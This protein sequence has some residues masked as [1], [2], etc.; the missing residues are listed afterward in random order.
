MI[1]PILSFTADEIWQN[2]PGERAESVFLS[3][4]ADGQDQYPELQ[5]LP[6]TFW[7]IILA[8]KT[9]VN[10]ELEVKRAD[11]T[12]G[13]SLS[14]EV[15]LYCD[16]ELTDQLSQLG[17][18]LQFALIVSRATVQP[19]DDAVA[20]AVE[21]EV[22]GLKLTVTASQHPKCDRCWH[23]TADVGQITAHPEL[24]P[25]CVDNIDG[26]GEVREFV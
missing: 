9:A 24:C 7:Q 16:T 21:T 13:S 19:L 11:K 17:A 26:E 18:E 6:D 14:A 3:N 15:E 4:F 1:A 5:A 2:I 20:A 23:H 22:K 25:R 12:V 10:K 8:V